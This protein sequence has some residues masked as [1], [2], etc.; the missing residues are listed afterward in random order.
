MNCWASTE[1]QLRYKKDHVLTDDMQ[2]EL[3]CCAELMAEA[4]QI[5]QE[6][7]TDLLKE[8]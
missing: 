6:L 8:D 3:K 5:M 1:H 7:A 2:K 4:D